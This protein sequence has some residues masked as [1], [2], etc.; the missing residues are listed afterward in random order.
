MKKLRWGAARSRKCGHL[1]CVLA[2]SL[3]LAVVM[4]SQS[5]ALYKRL[6]PNLKAGGEFGESEMTTW[7]D[8]KRCLAQIRSS[9]WSRITNF[10]H[11]L[12]SYHAHGRHS[13]T[14]RFPR[15]SYSYTLTV[16]IDTYSDEMCVLGINV[17]LKFHVS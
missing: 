2:S 12:S 3:G 1:V 7:I 8:E 5:G 17:Q 13:P 4:N 14:S 15:V 6:V 10:P 9:F 11:I 16:S